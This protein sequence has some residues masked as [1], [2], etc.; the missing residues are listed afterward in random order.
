MQEVR[1]DAAYQHV[2]TPSSC[3]TRTRDLVAVRFEHNL[4]FQLVLL[5]TSVM[6]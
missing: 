6:F 1:L 5:Y 3:S 2:I 4:E